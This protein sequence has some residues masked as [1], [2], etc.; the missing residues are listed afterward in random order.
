M[1]RWIWRIFAASV[2]LATSGLTWHST[3]GQAKKKDAAKAPEV[4]LSADVV[5]YVR[6][7]GSSAHRKEWEQ[8]A[9]YQ[10]LVKSGLWK[11]GEQ[12]LLALSKQH[13]EAD[14][15]AQQLMPLIRQVTMDGASAG[16]RINKV[17]DE[18]RPQLTA[19][20]HKLA[21]KEA[22]VFKLLKLADPQAREETV[23]GKKVL[24]GSLGPN[25]DD[26][27]G[28]WSDGGHIVLTMGHDAVKSV[29]DRA[30]S[31]TPDVRG[32]DLWRKNNTVPR[33]VTLMT[34]GWV[35]LAQIN[36][37]LKSMP[38]EA[39]PAKPAPTVGEVL[40]VFLG[41][42]SA[43]SLVM[44]SGMQGKACW[45]E[46]RLERTGPLKGLLKLAD[47]KTF[48][49]SDLP[50]LPEKSASFSAVAI[51]WLDTYDEGWNQIR[52]VA[53]K[54]G[55]Q[56][57]VAKAE[58]QWKQ[59]Q[60]QQLGWSVRDDL[61]A[62]LGEMHVMYYDSAG[63]VGPGVGMGIAVQV[64]DAAKIRTL[65]DQAIKLIPQGAPNSPQVLRNQKEEQEIISVGQ[66]GVPVWPSVCVH[67]KWLIAGTTA[68]TVETFLQRLDGKL[69][70]WKPDDELAKTL[71]ELPQ[72]FQMISVT[73]PK[74]IVLSIGQMAPL[75]MAGLMAAQGQ[76]GLPREL[77]AVTFP[78]AEQV[79]EPLF[80]NVSV[81]TIEN[82]KVVL[83]ARNSLPI[84]T[85]GD[86]STIAVGAIGVALLLPAV[87]Q[88]REAARRTQSRNNLKQI[89][90]ALHNYHDTFKA[91]PAGTVAGP[92]KSEDRLSWQAS[93]LPYMDQAP[94]YN[95]LDMKQ[96]WQ[97]GKNAQLG[98]SAIPIL[99]NPA[100]TDPKIAGGLGRTDYV[101]IAG[102]GEDG[103][104]K[105]LDDRG[106]GF[107]AYDRATRL[108]DVTDGTSNTV[109]VG[110]VT[111]DRGPWIQG[112]A[113]TIR[114]LTKQPYINGPD[115]FGGGWRGGSHFL[116]SD[117]AVRFISENIDPK[118]MEALS[119]IRG[120]EVLGD[121]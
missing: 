105:K 71:E 121:F 39:D 53:A 72:S 21:P 78:S 49:L 47:A 109:M 45:S 64:K 97:G 67:D 106:A 1:S 51:N 116:L 37:L 24:R 70:A 90:L 10:S 44:Q 14:K 93:I 52:A 41:L 13:P 54:Y 8:T 87:Q 108:Q 7:D 57:A 77:T 61:L 91:F 17:G 92:A 98:Q 12:W 119:T 88:A 107:F 15:I 99:N 18:F 63:T 104:K 46:M 117:G 113:A 36:R 110:E 38:V 5:G 76:Q 26:E 28:C 33:G 50:P 32:S 101:G 81:M 59:I 56:D 40:D 94:L 2:V 103:P 118:L 27:W 65:V 62:S 114:P 85:G 55:E 82:G 19:V 35:D 100:L 34:V 79:A 43:Q 58:E 83:T 48:S 115:G 3:W 23:Q 11:A 86:A 80:P 68:A 74:S 120:G 111:K 30:T 60:E 6:H 112:G 31:K 89:G 4:F 16:V 22:D 96:G 69:P 66:P 73:D 95:Q 84:M 9:A 102:L 42:G 75:M 20:L 29:M 25:S